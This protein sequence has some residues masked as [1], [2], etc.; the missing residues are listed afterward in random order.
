MTIYSY[1]QRAIVIILLVLITASYSRNYV[2]KN[3]YTLWKDVSHKS[4]NK[5]VPHIELGN[6][7]I[8]RNALQYAEREFNV[9]LNINPQD[10]RALNGLAVIFYKRGQLD[11][12]IRVFE[13]LA[14]DKADNPHFHSNLGVMYMEKGLFDAAIK[15]FK[16]A[17]DLDPAYPETYGNLGLA[18]M[19]KGQLKDARQAYEHALRIYP[20]FTYAQKQLDEINRL[21]QN[22]H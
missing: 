1:R 22:K 11:E 21:L 2:W 12:A 14:A 8:R 5:I 4:P 3:E 9:A 10:V 7:F 6:A 18:F 17:V 13:V 19:K 16:A 15:E 20:E